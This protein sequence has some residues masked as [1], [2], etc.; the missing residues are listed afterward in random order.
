[1]VVAFDHGDLGIYMI[2]LSHECERSWWSYEGTVQY[3][4][5]VIMVLSLIIVC[6][7]ITFNMIMNV[8]VLTMVMELMVLRRIMV[9]MLRISHAS[10]GDVEHIIELVVLRLTMEV[11]GRMILE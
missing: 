2:V 8:V 10:S 11:V 9:M 4:I 3:V 7:Y 5:M 6:G 1:M